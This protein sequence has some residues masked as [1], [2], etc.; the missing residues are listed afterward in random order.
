[1]SSPLVVRGYRSIPLGAPPPPRRQRP[2]EV[3]PRRKARA[4][5]YATEHNVPAPPTGPPDLDP[6]T[7][8][9]R[10]LSAELGEIIADT[11][12]FL[13]QCKAEDHQAEIEAAERARQRQFQES[14]DQLLQSVGAVAERMER[15]E[16]E[17]LL[18]RVEEL[19]LIATDLDRQRNIARCLLRSAQEMIANN[20]DG[21]SVI[22]MM[23]QSLGSLVEPCAPLREIIP[24]VQ[25]RIGAGWDVEP[26]DLAEW[27]REKAITILAPGGRG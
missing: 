10:E 19:E 6:R 27:L 15:L 16:L 5:R 12:A 1:M 4:Q 9:L 8:A 3:A 25:G 2:E 23:E 26:D 20:R 7:L 24:W 21:N 14:G 11:G 22:A 17:R 18:Q 13:A